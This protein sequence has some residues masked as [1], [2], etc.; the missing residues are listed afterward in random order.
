MN[1]VL[2]IICLV[3]VFNLES[4]AQIS[5]KSIPELYQESL[6]KPMHLHTF[7][8]LPVMLTMQ[9]PTTEIPN[10]H[11]YEHLAFFCRLE[12][13]MEQRLKI[14]FKFRL[15]DVPYVDRLEGKR[16]D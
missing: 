10:V 15:G 4:T 11:R 7:H 9:A 12:V 14:P 3:T 6:S 8:R 16:R 1:K 2:I 13:K 5:G